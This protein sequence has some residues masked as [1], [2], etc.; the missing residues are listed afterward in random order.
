MA[1]PTSDVGFFYDL[2]G[3]PAVSLNPDP[4]LED[5]KRPVNFR[6]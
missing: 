2:I 4:G 6:P 3:F 5:E 1:F